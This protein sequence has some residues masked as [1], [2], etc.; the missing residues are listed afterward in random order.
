M[1]PTMNPFRLAVPQKVDGQGARRLRSNYSCASRSRNAIAGKQT[2]ART[3]FTFAALWLFAIGFSYGQVDAGAILGTIRDSS[4]AFIPGVEVTIVN[5]E[6]GLT[7]ATRS[8]STGEYSFAPVRIGNYVLAAEMQGFKR[9]EQSHVTVAVQQHVLVDLVLPPGQTTQ[10]VLVTGEPPA[11]QTQDASVGQVIEAQTI[12]SLPLNG[13]N[14]IFLAQLSAGVTQGQQDSRGLGASGSFAANGLQPAQNNFLLDGLDN[15]SNLV[16]FLNGSSFAIRPPIDAIQEFKIQTN[17][18][19]AE[20]GR[21]A[22]AILNATVKSGTSQYHGN[23]WE[24]V[25]NDKLDAANYFENAGGI[26]KGEFRLNQFGATIGG[27]IWKHKTFFFGDYEGTRIRQAVPYV[28]TVPTNLERSSGYTNLSELLNQGGTQMDILGRTTP[29]GQVFDPS[30]TRQVSC[31][32]P[33]FPTG[34]TVPCDGMPA[35]SQIGFAREVFPGNI[36][37]TGRLDPNAVKLL[38]LYPSPNNPNLFNNYTTN[39]VQRN[40]VD[41]FDIRLDQAIREKDLLFGRGS[42]AKN[43][44]FVPGP[45]PG[46]ADG[47][48]FIAGNQ[49]SDLT[50]WVVSETHTFSPSLVNQVL[51]GRNNMKVVRSQ[52]FANTPGIPEQFGI[53]GI[54]QGHLNGGLG[55][56]SIAGLSTLGSNGYLPSDESSS[57]F[58]ITDNLTKHFNRQTLTGGFEFQRLAF[59][60]LQPPA[61]RGTFSFSGLY[62]EVP[63]SNNGSTGLAQL[64]LS[65]TKGAFA[66]AADYVGG[67]DSV[68]ASNVATT[69]QQHNYYGAYFQDDFQAS[70]KLTLNLGLRWEYFG[71]IVVPNGEQSNF[72][73]AA[74]GA[75]AQ[76]L[77]TKKRCDT[78]LSPTFR[79]AAQSDSIDISCSGQPGLGESQRI[80][81]SPRV[82]FA[83][84]LTPKTVVRGGYGIFYGGFSNSTVETY[85]DFPF[86]FAL[87]Y[88]NLTPDAPITYPNGA[89]GTLETGLSAIPLTSGAVEPAGVSFTG[90]DY[91]VKTPYTQGYNLT[92]QYQLAPN[93]TVQVGYVGNAVRHL[94]VYVNPNAPNQILP[95]GLNAFDYSPYPDFQNGFTFTRFAGDSSY[96]S[97]QATY[98]HRFSAG[99]SILA[100]YTWSKCRTDAVDSLNS[101]AINLRNGYNLPHFGIQGDYGLCD[102]DIRHVVHLSGIYELPVGRGKRFLP[103]SSRLL[104]AV[105]GGWSLNWILPLQGGQPGTVPCAISTTSGFGCNANVVKSQHVLASHRGPNQWL[106]PAA[107]TSPPVATAIGQP[108]YSPLGGAPSQFSGPPYRRLDISL[109]KNFATSDTTHLEFRA[110]FFNLTNTPNFANPSFLDY[111]SD[112]FGRITST[113]D[114]QNDPRETQLALKFYW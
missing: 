10:T 83:Y 113:R 81:F 73:P 55:K 44:Q 27:P 62:T 80:N 25:R 74:P 89:I 87:G 26:R 91:H 82:G 50:S 3:L 30:T 100:N 70:P 102:F 7:A 42:Y 72:L 17:N 75:H 40:D 52:P 60:V 2:W 109:F 95:P 19:S 84:L 85:V 71:Q 41:Q 107:F 65:P 4:G 28:T 1:E 18:Y 23:A 108:D 63:T 13:R 56:I 86:Q 99:L 64:L 39:P 103:T 98:E 54:P 101:T 67:A 36:L 20:F 90:E 88:G 61:G 110:E 68:G 32:V 49:N 31:G 43:P 92:V 37:P 112:T 35:G 9:V 21:S 59:S 93:D 5:G 69:D 15:N 38:N 76:F 12:N 47:G 45:F 57:T 14:F 11:L 29:L 34:I 77:L 33:D 104:D 114:G 22:G 58:Q 111:T 96:N 66:G 46:I 53:Q 48:K 79:A 51:A 8:G 97:L 105:V 94:G 16:D 106:N 6:T 24:F 78:P